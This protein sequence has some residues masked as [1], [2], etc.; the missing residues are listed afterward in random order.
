MKM[1]F[2]RLTC[3]VPGN[4]VYDL[5]ETDIDCDTPNYV[6]VVLRI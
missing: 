3:R 5:F 6:T 1:V 2:S 4:A